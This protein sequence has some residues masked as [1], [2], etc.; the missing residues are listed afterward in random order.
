M[1]GEIDDGRRIGQLYQDVIEKWREANPHTVE[2]FQSWLGS[3]T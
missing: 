1:A 2:N 3:P